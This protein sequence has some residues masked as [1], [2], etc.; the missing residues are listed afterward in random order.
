MITGQPFKFVVFWLEREG[1]LIKK[2]KEFKSHHIA[3][4]EPC[5][6]LAETVTSA[7]SGP[8][9]KSPPFHL[10]VQL[11]KK[12]CC[13]LWASVNYHMP[14]LVPVLTSQPRFLKKAVQELKVRKSYFH[15]LQKAEKQTKFWLPRRLRVN[16]SHMMIITSSIILNESPFTLTLGKCQNTLEKMSW[17]KPRL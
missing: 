6:Y 1:P 7:L 11:W 10:C 9:T 16:P 4:V 12:N 14:L 5:P 13:E 15:E 2:M 17:R 8:V 3:G